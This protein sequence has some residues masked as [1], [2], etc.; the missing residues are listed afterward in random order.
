MLLLFFHFPIF[1]FSIRSYNVIILALFFTLILKFI[2]INSLYLW[3][4]QA[5]LFYFRMIDKARVETLLRISLLIIWLN[6]EVLHK[7]L[8]GLWSDVGNVKVLIEFLVINFDIHK[9]FF[10]QLNFSEL[11]Q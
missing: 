10:T 2:Q 8:D 4:W 11:L 1:L 7:S 6:V 9:F 5:V 3:L